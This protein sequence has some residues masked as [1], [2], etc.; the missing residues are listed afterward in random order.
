MVSFN[1]WY[2]RILY[3]DGDKED[4]NEQD[5][6]DI[7]LSP[8]LEKAEV[9]V[10]VAVHWPSDDK[11]Y[12]AT[13]IRERLTSKKPYYLEYDTG[14]YEWLDLGKVKFCILGGGTRRRSN[15][16]VEDDVHD[17]DVYVDGESDSDA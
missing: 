12:E 17:S 7:V 2:Y 11:F 9:G 5:L 15:T 10:R 3:S 8:E 6:D 14:H 1:G 16:L 4:C 13:I